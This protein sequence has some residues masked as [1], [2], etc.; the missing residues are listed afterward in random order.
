MAGERPYCSAGCGG[1]GAFNLIRRSA[2]DA[3]GGWGAMRMEVIEDM[4]MGLVLKRAG[5]VTHAVT[6]RD[7]LRIRW[8]RAPG[9]SCR[10]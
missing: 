9:A 2:Y 3:V 4:R 10:T 7:L 5:F 6:G 1:L 8:P